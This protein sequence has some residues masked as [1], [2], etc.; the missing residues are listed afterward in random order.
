MNI[1][2]K[3]LL[4]A[5]VPAFVVFLACTAAA[6]MDLNRL[7]EHDLESA[8]EFLLDAEKRRLK[9]LVEVA[10]ATADEINRSALTP[11]EKKEAIYERLKHLAY[12]SDGYVFGYTSQGVRTLLG[13]STKGLGNNYWNL[14]DKKGTLLI[15]EMIRAGKQG[16][17]YVTY[18]FPK[19][20]QSEPLPK[21][22]YSLYLPEQDWIIGTGVYIDHI[23]RELA[24]I[25]QQQEE[26]LYSNAI[27]LVIVGFLCLGVTLIIV[28]YI[29]NRLTGRIVTIQERL[30][31]IAQG[32]GDLTHRLPITSDDEL[33]ALAR[34]FNEFVGKIHQ[35]IS[36]VL[37][38]V[39]GLNETSSAM[40][41]SASGT[42]QSIHSQHKETEMVATA[43]S[44]MS[45]SSVQVAQS[46]EEAANAA[47]TAQL[48]GKK[49][50]SVIQTASET[51]ETLAS[52]LD[53]SSE[54][55]ASLGSDV[56][57]IVSILDV[58]RGIAEQTNLL[59]LNA[60]IEAA[61]AGEQGRGFAVVADE[62]RSLAGR[63]QDSTAE[64]QAMIERLENGSQQAITA[65]S[66]SKAQGEN[67][68]EQTRETS[69]SLQGVA[70]A[71]EHISNMNTQIATAAEEQNSVSESI[72]ESISR[73]ADSSKE[74][75]VHADEATQAS[76]E[77]SVVS[78]ELKQLL[79][80]FKV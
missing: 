37:K 31:D 6:L 69:T 41:H 21:L 10:K 26:E 64:I 17:G 56:E 75:L 61:R 55:L 18:Y 23:D 45:A 7:S 20:G 4:L 34:A 36:H 29:S 76:E 33:G 3:F 35:T 28:S 30:L 9:N 54:T 74:T 62:V 79:N 52:G 46:A 59:A 12:G 43:M 42:H 47:N 27:Q 22:S 16:G 58:I 77:L 2:T 14:K 40:A 39:D 24:E 53:N 1:R 65:M 48:D 25:A 38:M 50:L 63:T 73:I 11:N 51:I 8:Q 78:Q 66:R 72:D 32:E 5:V 60:A 49:A 80:Q 70:N 57:S 13:T 67:A 68:V 19:P 44:E 71:I 15:Q